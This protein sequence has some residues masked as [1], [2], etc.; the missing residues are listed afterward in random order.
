MILANATD[1][2]LK[3]NNVVVGNLG[4]TEIELPPYEYWYVYVAGITV[5][6]FVSGAVYIMSNGKIKA[7]PYKSQKRK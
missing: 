4:E 1:I 6:V 5:A 2:Q 3:T 7:K